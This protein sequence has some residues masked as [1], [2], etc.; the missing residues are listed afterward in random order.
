MDFVKELLSVL[1][2]LAICVFIIWLAYISTKAIA[3]SGLIRQQ[4][5]RNIEILESMTIGREKQLVIARVC[6]EMLLL[7]VTP[8]H[9]ELI[10]SLDSEGF[11]GEKE[12]TQPTAPMPF[13]DALKKVM[14]DKFKK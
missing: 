2:V 5:T 6:G 11:E 13:S 4:S 7:G 9:I 3:K 10:S 8:N 1:F 14:K 12:Q